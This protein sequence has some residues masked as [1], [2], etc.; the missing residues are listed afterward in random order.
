M[1]ALNSVSALVPFVPWEVRVKGQHAS[2]MGTDDLCKSTWISL[3][4]TEATQRDGMEGERRG[5][6][7]HLT[8]FSC[9]G[10]D[11]LGTRRMRRLRQELRLII[12]TSLHLYTFT[13]FPGVLASSCLPPLSTADCSI[14]TTI[15]GLLSTVW[16]GAVVLW[17]LGAVMWCGEE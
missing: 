15:C 7:G 13:A 17:C 12:F 14:R 10:S 4:T 16:S 3:A 11:V 5:R 6:L 9:L 2:L 1:W 8:C